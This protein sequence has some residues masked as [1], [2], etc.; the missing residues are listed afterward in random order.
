[1]FAL[2]ATKINNRIMFKDDSKTTY[3]VYNLKKGS[4]NIGVHI[5]TIKSQQVLLKRVLE[6]VLVEILKKRYGVELKL[7]LQIRY[8]IES[9]AK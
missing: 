9:G 8:V 7:M 6:R 3:Q 1:M 2:I 5:E 4:E